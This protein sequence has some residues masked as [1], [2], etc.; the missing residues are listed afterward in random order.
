M[1]DAVK[2]N[3]RSFTGNDVAISYGVCSL[4]S[5]RSLRFFVFFFGFI[6]VVKHRVHF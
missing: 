6:V 4:R 2:T 5:L 3:A 1:S